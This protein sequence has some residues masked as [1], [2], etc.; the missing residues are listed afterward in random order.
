VSRRAILFVDASPAVG[1]ATRVLLE[2]LAA[3]RSAGVN[4]SVVCRA[5]SRV[6]ERIRSEGCETIP[7]D[8][9]MLTFAGGVGDKAMMLSRWVRAQTGIRALLRERQ[10]LLVHANGIASVLVAGLPARAA[11]VPLAWHVH[12]LLPDRL[13]FTPIVRLA[14]ALSRSAVCVSE[15]T[16]ARLVQGG[17]PA[18]KCR[19]VHNGV[20]VTSPIAAVPRDERPTVLAAGIVTPLKGHHVLV[21]AAALLAKRHPGLRVLVA[22]EPAQDGDFAYRDRLLAETRRLGLDATVEFLGYRDDLR[23]LVAAATVVVHPSTEEET[24]GLVPLEA[25]AEGRPVVATRIG[26]IPEVV[27]DGVSGILVPPGDPGALAEAIGR[28]LDDPALR[29]RM[30]EA[31]RRIAGERF[32]LARMRAGLLDALDEA[33]GG[34]LQSGMRV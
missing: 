15:A 34:A 18:G 6:E 33:S 23:R 20:A 1:G 4:G 5:G 11:G 9:P 29:Q 3:V 7:M 12:D 2:T 8:L 19:V 28:L 10:P 16:R 31:G 24:F 21:A 30:G 22:G 32:S 26:G 13:P 14:G 25:M 17:V 27:E